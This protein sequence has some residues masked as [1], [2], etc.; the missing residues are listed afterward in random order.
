M[1]QFYQIFWF[2]LVMMISPLN[3]SF[4]GV[5]SLATVQLYR[6]S[7]CNTSASSSTPVSLGNSSVSIE[8]DT[9]IVEELVTYYARQTD[10]AGNPSDCSQVYF[11]YTYDTT[12]QPP[13]RLALH[14]PPSSSGND[15][16][17]EVLV[18]GLESLA[19]VQLYSDSS[20]NTSASSPA[21]VSLGDSSVIVE[22]DASNN[23]WTRHLLRSPNRCSQQSFRLFFS[24]HFLYL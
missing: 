22:A 13:S 11:S 15:S 17:P 16:T 20:C 3:S 23:R 2:S 8:A 12:A 1:G 18:S 10:V 5:E 19:T 21:S 7:S 6:D 14:N 4:Q 24:P 9:L